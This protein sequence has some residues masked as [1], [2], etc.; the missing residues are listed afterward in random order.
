M[1]NELINVVPKYSKE[2][3][4]SQSFFH[5][6]AYNDDDALEDFRDP[7]AIGSEYYITTISIKGVEGI[8]GG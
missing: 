6:R 1:N 5:S 2:T 4:C 7:F 8:A 3:S